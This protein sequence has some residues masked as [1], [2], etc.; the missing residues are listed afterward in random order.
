[1]W[2][3]KLRDRCG[4]EVRTYEVQW[5]EYG[6][7]PSQNMKGCGIMARGISDDLNRRLVQTLPDLAD[8]LGGRYPGKA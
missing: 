4:P 2:P 7:K 3:Q 1:M 6:R 5:A 8:A